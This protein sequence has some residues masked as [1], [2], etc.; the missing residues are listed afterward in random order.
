MKIHL[1]NCIITLTL[2]AAAV[3]SPGTAFAQDGGQRQREKVVP[4]PWPPARLSDG[5]P[6]IS[7]YWDPA[8]GGTYSLT[9]PSRGGVGLQ[10]QL[11]IARRK[12]PSRIVDPPDGQIPYQP[13]AREKQKY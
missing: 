8:I 1:T 12:N 13:W 5:Q 6:D 4:A 10:D 3:L 7:G 2:A 11:G 9:N